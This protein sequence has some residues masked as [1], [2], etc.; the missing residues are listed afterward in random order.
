MRV[1]PE[2]SSQGEDSSLPGI[3]SKSCLLWPHL[4]PATQ[5]TSHSFTFIE[6]MGA[7]LGLLMPIR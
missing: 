1:N 5:S 2:D 4:H 7:Q 6:D 3:D